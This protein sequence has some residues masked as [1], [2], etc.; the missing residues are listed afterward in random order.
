MLLLPLANRLQM[1]ETVGTMS[2]RQGFSETIDMAADD[3]VKKGRPVLTCEEIHH[4]S[5]HTNRP[6]GVLGAGRSQHPYS[7]DCELYVFR[8]AI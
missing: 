3:D 7:G 1:S 8:T 6:R 5:R 2:A 4:T